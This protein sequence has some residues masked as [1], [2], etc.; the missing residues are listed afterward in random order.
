MSDKEYKVG[1]GKPPMH[2]RFKKGQS[3]NS[4]GRPKGSKNLAT[5][6]KEE[7]SRK[8]VVT[9]N[10]V[11]RKVT[12]QRAIVIGLTARAMKDPKAASTVISTQLKLEPQEP[13][14]PETKELSK[15]DATILE[16]YRAS[17]LEEKE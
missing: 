3:G 10:G 5:D 17:I 11:E 16:Q 1:Y 7:L 12:K 4:R 13:D 9:E 14:L 15:T 2:S 8:I 6:M